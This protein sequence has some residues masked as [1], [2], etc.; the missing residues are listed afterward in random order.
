MKRI[1]LNTTI[2]LSMFFQLAAEAQQKRLTQEQIFGGQAS[3]TQ[4]MPQISGWKDDEHYLEIDLQDRKRYATDIKTGKR[5][6]YP[7]TSE[8][9]DNIPVAQKDGEKNLTFSPDG[10]YVAFT[11]NND[12]YARELSTGRE[13]R[14]TTDATDVIYNGW[15]SWVYYEEILGR[16]TNYKAFWWSPD[17]KKLAFMRFD[18]TKVPMFPI[19]GSTGQHGYTEKTRYPK[20]GDPES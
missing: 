6:L 17:S 9:M 14:Y 2:A 12:L 10:K 11:Y 3:L 1:L 8:N 20:A 7:Y 16:A 19:N 5:V 18:D 15:S 13:I 4:Q